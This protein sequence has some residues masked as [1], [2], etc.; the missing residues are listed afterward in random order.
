MIYEDLA[1]NLPDDPDI[2]LYSVCQEF[3]KKKKDDQH[4]EVYIEAY[5]LLLAV[6]RRHGVH[7]KELPLGGDFNDNIRMVDQ[8][9]DFFARKYQS[10]LIER[11]TKERAVEAQITYTRLI[12]GA[13]GFEL[14]DGDFARIQT[15]ITELREIITGNTGW[16]DD[17]KQRLLG[18]LEAL[19]RELHKKMNNLDRFWGLL[20][21]A[22][23]ALGKFGESAKPF[24]DRV[25]ELLEII[26][27]A[28]ARSQELPSRA[29][30]PLPP[31]PSSE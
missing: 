1:M 16:P 27:S 19:Q 14:S 13:R 29:P 18:R 9:F 8:L 17:F 21:D 4:Y 5:A 28:E 12:R 7:F 20:P 15:L 6:A 3:L 26:W 25:R 23:V 11:Q 10:V 30:A 31:G 24:F 22:G 2:A